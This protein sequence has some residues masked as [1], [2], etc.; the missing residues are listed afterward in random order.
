MKN[1]TKIKIVSFAVITSLVK[2]ASCSDNFLDKTETHEINS[3][4]YFNSKEDYQ[5]ALIGAYD[6]L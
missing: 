6:L 3:E 1:F 2:L 5:K 4:T